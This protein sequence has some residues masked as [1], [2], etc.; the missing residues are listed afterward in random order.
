MKTSRYFG[1]LLAGLA[2]GTIIVGVAQA[3]DDLAIARV[4]TGATA[5]WITAY[6]CD[7]TT[8][9]NQTLSPDGDYTVCGKTWSKEASAGDGTAMAVT[10]G[11]GLVI[12]PAQTPDLTAGTRT[13][14]RLHLPISSVISGFSASTP[15]RV[16]AYYSENIAAQFD[17]VAMAFWIEQN[18]ST[19]AWF[20]GEYIFKSAAKQVGITRSL[21]GTNGPEPTSALW[22]TPNVMRM[23][24]AGG[25]GN[26]V[27]ALATGTYSSGFP[28]DTA[29]NYF[30]T[31]GTGDTQYWG[32]P[33][34]PSQ[35]ELVLTAM[36]AGSATALNVTFKRLL[37]EYR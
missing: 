33:T 18:A 24:A 3:A 4:Q 28:A 7:F 34:S 8:Q 5:G 26:V 10:N 19:F 15:I 32:A 31:Y 25:L 2:L 37:V 22:G 14:P 35:Y 16:T 27:I 12:I 20:K 21:Q 30:T 13:A 9:S 1:A 6:D 36:R 23:E 17:Q 11:S 29:M